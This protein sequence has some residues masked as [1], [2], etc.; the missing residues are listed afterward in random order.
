MET[1]INKIYTEFLK[2]DQK[3]ST[4]TRKISAGCLFFALRG[5][6][7]NGNDYA[8][9]AINEGASFSIVDDKNLEPND[10]LIFTENVL[11]TLQQVSNFHRKQLKIKVIALTGSNGKTTTKE[12]INAVLSRK[13]KIH[14]TQ[15]N[16]NNHIGVPLTL[17]SLRSFHEFA[18][19]EMGANHRHE[20][21]LL[22]KIAEPDFG[23]ITNIGK[24][25]LEGFGG[26]EG[27]KKGKGELYD[28]LKKTNGKIFIHADDF[29][30]NGMIAEKELTRSLIS[31]GKN[32]NYDCTGAMEESE[33]F[34]KINWRK[35]NDSEI[36][37]ISS[38]LTGSY[39]FENILAAVCIGN[40]FGVEKNMIKKGIEG[41]VPSNQRSQVVEKNSNTFILDYYNANPSSM[42]AALLNFDKAF[43]GK[44][45]AVLGDMLELGN[46]SEKE[47]RLIIHLTRELNFSETIF[48]GKNFGQFAPKESLRTKENQG[49]F[50]DTSDNA[51]TWIQKQNFKNASL[52]IKGSRGLKMEKVMEAFEV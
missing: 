42:E 11:E 27:V 1:I 20:I 9:D 31:Y 49:I 12:L 34:L 47:H 44:K 7:F 19:V 13:F 36:N 26:L 33:Q 40:Y 24:A 46:E 28:F 51:K 41:Y 14:A 37:F 45:I 50:F 3:I 10:R 8:N 15:G 23:L 48:V 43:G 5:E 30:L 39:N 21:E 29:V 25:H 52:L 18:V 22:C 6:N 35:K 32:E 38:H 2:A 4:D 17:L 16:L